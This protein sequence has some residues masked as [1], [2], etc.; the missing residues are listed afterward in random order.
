MKQISSSSQLNGVDLIGG[1]WRT[2]FELFGGLPLDR[3]IVRP[4]SAGPT[5]TNKASTKL[6]RHT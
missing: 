6:P 3:H 5:T 2:I 4:T 1:P